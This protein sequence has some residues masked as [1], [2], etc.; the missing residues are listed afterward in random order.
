MKKLE[1]MKRDEN[2]DYQNKLKEFIKLQ[3]DRSLVADN[4]FL[5]ANIKISE[6]L[7]KEPEVI[8]GSVATLV[9][10]NGESWHEVHFPT[11]QASLRIGLGNILS[12]EYV[13]VHVRTDDGKDI[14]G[15]RTVMEFAHGVRRPCFKAVHST[16]PDVQKGEYVPI[17]NGDTFQAFTIEQGPPS[18][19]SLEKKSSSETPVDSLHAPELDWDGKIDDDKN[20]FQNGYGGIPSSVLK[21]HEYIERVAEEEQ[22]I[23]E[24]GAKKEI[25][26]EI[27]FY[28]PSG[29]PTDAEIKTHSDNLGIEPA[30]F[31]AVLEQES[32]QRATAFNFS[33]ENYPDYF[34]K[35][36][37]RTQALL[38]CSAFGAPQVMGFNYGM[39]GFA[40]PEDMLESVNQG[41]G[42]QLDI[43]EQYIRN[44]PGMLTAMKTLDYDEIARK[45]AGEYYEKYYPGYDNSIRRHYERFSQNE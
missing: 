30:I 24:I 17:W 11:D 15:Y 37:D 18:L 34:R 44:K 9:E 40:S 39:V 42:S 7:Q 41:I 29:S 28:P 36:K 10:I 21:N 6:V 16:D 12:D 13:Y 45:Y 4:E 1:Q 33:Y 26:N 31:K 23:E 22:W 5:Y 8:L 2:P 35:T 43:M 14:Y 19:Q 32:G 38:L 25:Q 3:S 20:S 27:G